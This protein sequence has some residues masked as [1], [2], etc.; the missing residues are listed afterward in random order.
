MTQRLGIEQNICLCCFEFSI[1][2]L[3]Q[4]FKNALLSLKVYLV[5]DEELADSCE[6]ADSEYY[7][8]VGHLCLLLK[9]SSAAG[10]QSSP[11]QY[12]NE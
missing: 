8:L 4:F 10:V 6:G 2:F 7:R 3:S 5:L 12:E 1:K 9:L 11:G